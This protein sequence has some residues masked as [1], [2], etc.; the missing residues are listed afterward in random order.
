MSLQD[1]DKVI[2]IGRPECEAAL[3]RQ[4]I[5]ADGRDGGGA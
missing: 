2:A 1:G 5:G 3:H 4:L